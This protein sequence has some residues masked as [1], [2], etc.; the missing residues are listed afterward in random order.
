MIETVE[1]HNF[2]SIRDQR[3]DL[4]PLT[5]FVGANG[6]GKTSVLQAIDLVSRAAITSPGQ[7]LTNQRH[8]DWLYTRGG[9]GNLS[10]ACRNSVAEVKMFATPPDPSLSVSPPTPGKRNWEPRIQT[11]TRNEHGNFSAENSENHLL[12]PVRQQEAFDVVRSLQYLGIEPKRMARASYSDHDPPRLG[13]DGR[14]LASVLAFMALND[15]DSFGELVHHMR[16]L[17]PNL[18]R[19][20]FRKAGVNRTEKEFIRVGDGPAVERRTNRVY[21]GEAIIVDFANAEGIPA[22]A[23]SEGTLIM[24]GLLTVL[25]GPS[26]PRIVLMDD[27]ERG[28][29][30]MAQKSLLGVIR[31]VMEKFP[32]LQILATAHSP[33]LLDDLR[34]EEIRLMTLGEDGS[35]ICGRLDQHP[36]FEKWKDEMAPGEL[37]SLFGEKWLLQGGNA[38]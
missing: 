16:S 27:I 5:V 8:C 38:R 34:P 17:I 20:R 11:L 12:G 13:R 7:V 26:H 25:V 2:K 15:P 30:P 18:R 28:L 4:E 37:W 32:D 23:V 35:S 14:G 21:N 9:E 31:K 29:H 3:I 24:L 36:E 6:S 10:V 1:I 22:H 33:Y 19:I